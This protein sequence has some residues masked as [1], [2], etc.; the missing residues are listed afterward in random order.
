MS[1]KSHNIKFLSIALLLIS[2]NLFSGRNSVISAVENSNPE[3]INKTSQFSQEIINPD[4]D[5]SNAQNSSEPINLEKSKESLY[6][7]SDLANKKLEEDQKTAQIEQIKEESKVEDSSNNNAHDFEK[8]NQDSDIISKVTEQDAQEIK[9]PVIENNSQN[10]DT[11]INPENQE[12]SNT[13]D[14]ITTETPLINNSESLEN[15]EAVNTTDMNSTDTGI[16][17]NLIEPEIKQ[18][19]ISDQINLDD[20]NLPKSEVVFEDTISTDTQNPEIQETKEEIMQAPIISSEEQLEELNKKIKS[21]P[22]QEILDENLQT[23][24]K[25][26]EESL[27]EYIETDTAN[28][29]ALEDIPDIDLE[30]ETVERLVG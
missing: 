17:E 27:P 10:T 29:R 4:A 15:K 2:F 16:S 8:T 5:I 19:T 18:E 12:I 1:M 9:E 6:S 3:L 25:I 21:S 7:K 23:E 30:S 22:A 28:I 24:E 26:Q 20:Q 13:T 11:Q 14:T